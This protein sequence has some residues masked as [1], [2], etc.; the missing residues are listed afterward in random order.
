MRGVVGFRFCA[1]VRGAGRR[2]AFSCS[3]Q[4]QGEQYRVAAI[5][6]QGAIELMREFDGF[7]GVAAMAG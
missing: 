3:E 1:V 2:S 5:D 7:S 4:E 6:A